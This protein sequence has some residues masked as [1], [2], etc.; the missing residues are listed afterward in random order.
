MHA[1]KTRFGIFSFLTF[2]VLLF[3]TT[4]SVHA[5]TCSGC[6]ITPPS[7][8]TTAGFTVSGSGC[9]A[10]SSITSVSVFNSANSS[11]FA[12]P[13][14]ITNNTFSVNVPAI[15][16]S[17]VYRV[18]ITDGAAT[19]FSCGTF[20]AET[21]TGNNSLT[22]GAVT[23]S[24]SNLC[25]SNCPSSL[26]SASTYYCACG[27]TGQTCCP[28][29]NAAGQATC[30]QTAASCKSGI[31]AAPSGGGQSQITAVD[32]CNVAGGGKGIPTAIG[33]IPI[34]NATIMTSFF[35]RWLVGIGGGIAFIM[36]LAA[37][38]QILTSSGDPKKLSAGQELLTSAVSGLI[39]IVFSIFALR[40]I[41]VNILGLF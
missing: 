1:R 6:V 12:A 7:A 32:T 15:G 28:T 18:L 23:A 5:M 40:L 35:M 4:S 34:D 22:C 39:L 17:G 21:V 10:A 16:T 29:G 24:F 2:L 20:V 30:S 31:C 36:I 37:G 3:Q 8:A 41:G 14:T 38:F 19:P 26:L 25:P 11:I 9:T 13:I 33:C 27:G